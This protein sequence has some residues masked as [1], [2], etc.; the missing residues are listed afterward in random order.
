MLRPL[1]NLA[2]R[3]P[4]GACAAGFC[5]LTLAAP[6]SGDCLTPERPISA[7]ADLFAEY[8]REI[9]ADYDRYFSESSAFIDCLD[10]AR[11]QAMADLAASVA[12]YEALFRAGSD[13]QENS[14]DSEDQ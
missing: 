4:C 1:R 3:G 13:R 6:A 7:D 8:R 5:L 12:E 14:S 9:L 10:Q 2:G 11:G